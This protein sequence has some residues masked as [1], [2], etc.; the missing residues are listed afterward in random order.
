MWK[1]V[2]LNCLL[3]HLAVS[4]LNIEYF[5]EGIFILKIL[6]IKFIILPFFSNLPSF[7]LL[8]NVLIRMRFRFRLQSLGMQVQ[9]VPTTLTLTQTV[10]IIAS[11]VM[12][13][14]KNVLIQPMSK[15]LHEERQVLLFLSNATVH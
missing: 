1:I 15:D 2:L 5:F 12:M 9:I 11:T 7:Q 14:V 13:L 10:P 4:V 8:S 6:S 3:V